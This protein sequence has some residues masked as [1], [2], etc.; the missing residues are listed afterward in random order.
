MSPSDDLPYWDEQDTMEY[1]E[2]AA[3]QAR[4]ESVYESWAET[5]AFNEE[6]E[7]PFDSLV[8]PYDE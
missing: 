8:D 4:I 5:M 2:F 7:P 3:E 1:L 6:M